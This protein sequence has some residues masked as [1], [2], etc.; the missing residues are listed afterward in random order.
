MPCTRPK[1]KRPTRS[2]EENREERRAAEYLMGKEAGRGTEGVKDGCFADR[3]IQ[4]VPI[5]KCR[6]SWAIF[7]RVGR[8]WLGVTGEGIKGKCICNLWCPLL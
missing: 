5:K 1:A 2:E 3:H 8:K 6:S 7:F 4:F